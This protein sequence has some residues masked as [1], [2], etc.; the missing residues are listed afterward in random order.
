MEHHKEL[1]ITNFDEGTSF[2]LAGGNYRIIISGAQTKGEFSVIE[3][4]V[5]PNAGPNPHSHENINESFYVLEGEITFQTERGKIRAKKGTYVNIPLGGL[6]HSFKNTSSETAIL[7]CTVTPA[8]LEDCFLEAN[9]YLTNNTEDTDFERKAKLT[10]IAEKYG[11]KMYQI[12]FF[13]DK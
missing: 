5:P 7:L 1:F 6:I 4:T 3:M 9:N 13:E 11:N 2:S 8:G 12:D 10:S